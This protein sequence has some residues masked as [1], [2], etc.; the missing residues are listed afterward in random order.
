MKGL[1]ER[2]ILETYLKSSS[3]STSEKDTFPHGTKS[4][5]TSV[6]NGTLLRKQCTSSTVPSA[7]IEEI[8]QKI[9]T[10]HF[11]HMSYKLRRFGSDRLIIKDT[12]LEEKCAFSAVSQLPLEEFS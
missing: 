12:L 8:L 3:K 6:I 11:Q 7:S 5:L 9:H 1:G 2:E 10:L 4:L